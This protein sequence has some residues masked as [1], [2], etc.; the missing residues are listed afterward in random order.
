MELSQQTS[1]LLSEIQELLTRYIVFVDESQPLAAAL[2]VMNTY[3]FDLH[4]VTPYLWVTAAEKECGK[5]LLLQV[6]ETV[7]NK[8]WLTV[9]TTQAALYH[10]IENRKPT[11]LIDELDSK[12][13]ETR[14]ALVSVLN[15]G[16][17]AR[18]VVSRQAQD[19]QG[20]WT[21][22][23]DYHVYSPKVMAGIG[24]YLQDT[25]LS[26]CIPV[27]LRR[28]MPTEQVADFEEDRTWG[29]TES[30]REN[31]PRWAEVARGVIHEMDVVPLEVDSARVKEIWKPLLAI[32][33]L[34]GIGELAR[35]GAKALHSERVLS[36]GEQLLDSFRQI[37]WGKVGVEDGWISTFGALFVLE[38]MED[39]PWGDVFGRLDTQRDRLKA[40]RELGRRLKLYNIPPAGPDGKPVSRQHKFEVGEHAGNHNGWHVSW[41]QDAWQRYLGVEMGAKEE[42]GRGSGRQSLEVSQASDQHGRGIRRFRGSSLTPREEGPSE[43]RFE[44]RG[45]HHRDDGQASG[46]APGGRHPGTADPPGRE[47]GARLLRG[48]FQGGVGQDGAVVPRGEGDDVKRYLCTNC[49]HERYGM[50]DLSGRMCVICNRGAYEVNP[51]AWGWAAGSSAEL[52]ASEK[53]AA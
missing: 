37:F 16:Y 22:D 26:R 29:E 27:E 35:V 1:E 41:F 13:A 32:A 12:T 8:P 39:R 18:G 14:N 36:E 30:L 33:D 38:D 6:L 40:A 52:A 23:E 44:A 7:V 24:S 47:V 4:S 49:K 11:V 21:I 5:S 10:R 34:A 15:A 25:T 2:F 53:E 3:L 28:K 45:N 48:G 46:N 51:N 42:S 17:R 20:N 31:L 9:D 50:M 43:A 19:R